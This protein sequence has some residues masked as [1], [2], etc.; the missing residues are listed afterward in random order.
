VL[1][2][3]ITGVGGYLPAERVTNAE[4]GKLVDTTDEWIV[5]RTGI[6]VRHR[7]APDQGTSD[8]AWRRRARRWPPPAGR[9][10]TSILSWSP[11]PRPT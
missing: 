7:A 10:P 4:I 6:R 5:E 2:S 8:L 1:R 11:P 9:P 3:A